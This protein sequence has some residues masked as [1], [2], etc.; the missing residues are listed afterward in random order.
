MNN[1]ANL[2]VLSNQQMRRLPPVSERESTT[3]R[4][5]Q[6]GE[7]NDRKSTAKV[8]VSSKSSCSSVNRTESQNT[9]SAAASDVRDL[10]SFPQNIITTSGFPCDS[11]PDATAV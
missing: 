5:D 9:A 3:C 11:D 4:N 8:K 7:C 10:H 2:P 6:V 1:A